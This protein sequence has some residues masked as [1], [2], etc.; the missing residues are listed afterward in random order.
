MRIFNHFFCFFDLINEDQEL[1]LFCLL[2]GGRRRGGS[3][4]AQHDAA[5]CGGRRRAHD[6]CPRAAPL[7][8]LQPEPARRARQERVPGGHRAR[9]RAD[10][11]G[12]LQRQRDVGAGEAALVSKTKRVEYNVRSAYNACRRLWHCGGALR[13]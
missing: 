9:V 5:A 11:A 12:A 8:D 6:A 1:I 13:R 4:G 3:G 10:G 2:K 7:R